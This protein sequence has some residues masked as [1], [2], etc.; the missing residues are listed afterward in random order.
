[1]PAL[2]D[3]VY[4]MDALTSYTIHF[5]QSANISDG[6]RDCT[7]SSM[8]ACPLAEPLIDTIAGHN[9]VS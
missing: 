2:N 7:E 1:M 8:I 9:G 3:A 6:P 5:P 4:G